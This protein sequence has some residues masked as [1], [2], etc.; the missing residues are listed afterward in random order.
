MTSGS[1]R[2]DSRATTQPPLPFQSA[3][4]GQVWVLRVLACRPSVDWP[5]VDPQWSMLDCG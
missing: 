1:C 5:V 3:F 4:D 2:D